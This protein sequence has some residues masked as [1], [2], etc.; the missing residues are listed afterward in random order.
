MTVSDLLGA[1]LCGRS[2]EPPSA[3]SRPPA[4]TQHL[5][6]GGHSTLWLNEH[7]NEARLC[8]ADAVLR[9]MLFSDR[10]DRSVRGGL[11]AH[12]LSAR[13]DQL[14]AP[15]E[16]EVLKPGQKDGLNVS[17]PRSKALNYNDT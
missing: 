10:N 15:A 12:G 14:S 6:Q 9:G 17:A 5:A 16:A 1:R 13:L 2:S 3:L 8:S 4:L 7:S 11:K